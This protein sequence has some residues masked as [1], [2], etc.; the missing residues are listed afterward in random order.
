VFF[1]RSD[2]ERFRPTELAFLITDQ[3]VARVTGSL[4][5]NRP[6]LELDFMG[7]IKLFVILIG[8]V[9]LGISP[10]HANGLIFQFDELADL[11]CTLTGEICPV[12]PGVVVEPDFT[13]GVSGKVLVFDLTS[14]LAGQVFANGDV[15]ITGFSG[16]IIGDLRFTTAG[17]AL[18]GSETCTV[19]TQSCLLIFYAFDNNG[20]A[21]DVG[22]VSGSFPF[23]SPPLQ[24]GVT[25]SASGAFLYTS[26]FVSY[27]GIIMLPP[28]QV[29]VPEPA[30]A[31]MF[32]LG[33]GAFAF[34]RRNKKR[35]HHETSDKNCPT[36]GVS[37]DRRFRN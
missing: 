12:L 23:Q 20:F 37:V 36:V 15:P 18:T 26:G 3:Q 35:R 8:L 22:F 5:P 19:G 34:L 17:G 30:T 10:L 14:E 6:F 33:L 9:G 21:A 13:G 32:L 25:Q 16:G 7:K 24:A 11:S 2:A 27:H 28:N 31:S 4:G 29:P 1:N